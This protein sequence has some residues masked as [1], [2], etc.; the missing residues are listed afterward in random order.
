MLIDA[1]CHLDE[2]KDFTLGTDVLPVTCGHSHHANVKSLGL[3]QKLGIPFAMGIAPQTALKEDL[4]QLEKWAHFILHANP[5]PNAIGEIGL[6]YHWA[7]DEEGIKKEK[8]VFERMLDLAGEMDLPVVIHCR[9][10]ESDVIKILKARSFS[11]IMMHFF[12]GN[13]KEAHDAIALGAYISV[14][15]IR[16]KE[17]KE[18]IKQIP[19]EKLLAETDSPAVAR[20]PQDVIRAVEYIAEAK[21]ID[22][23]TV[24]QQTAKNAINFFNIKL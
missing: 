19:L 12:S 24:A 22:V 5:K 15:P 9:K 2:I 11:R 7:K 20:T 23:K 16:S 6:D 21:N 17:R 10:A 13:L 1:H 18:I 4:S 3:A 14:P 8:I